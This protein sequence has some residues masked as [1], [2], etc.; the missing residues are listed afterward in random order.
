M[1]KHPVT[2]PPDVIPVQGISDG[3]LE[4]LCQLL[5]DETLTLL[6]RYGNTPHAQHREALKIV[7]ESAI[8]CLY[9]PS[10]IRRAFPLE[11]GMGKTTIVKALCQLIV[12]QNLDR[13]ILVTCY[14]IEDLGELRKEM[15]ESGVP[16]KEVAIVHSSADYAK[17]YPSV[18]KDR[19]PYHRILLASHERIKT[20]RKSYAGPDEFM[21]FFGRDHKLRKRDLVLWDEGLIDAESYHVSKSDLLDSIALWLDRYERM[22]AEWRLPTDEWRTKYCEFKEYL[23]D[24]QKKLWGATDDL[25]SLPHLNSQ[26]RD[27]KYMTSNLLCRRK[28]DNAGHAKN[29]GRLAE[30]AERGQVRVVPL[31]GDAGLVQYE[32]TI[33]ECFNKILILDASCPIRE[34][35]KYDGKLTIHRLP[36]T[37]NYAKVCLRWVDAKGSKSSFENDEDGKHF[38]SYADYFLWLVE[39]MYGKLDE[40]IVFCHLDRE[41]RVRE[42]INKAQE[43][44]GP[45]AGSIHLLHWGM[46][47]ASNKYRNARW[48]FFWGIQYLPVQAIA[49]LIIGQIGRLDYSFLDR[50]IDEVQGSEIAEGVYQAASRGHSRTT[51]EGMA[52]EQLID[53]IIPQDAARRV[54]PLLEEVMPGIQIEQVDTGHFPKPV[55][56]NAKD[57][58]ELGETIRAHVAN[59]SSSEVKVSTKALIKALELPIKSGS[60]L[61]KNAMS[62]AA[63]RLQGWYRT[64]KGFARKD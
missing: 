42:V 24:A 33:D 57:Y 28:G 35:A 58:I 49:A 3:E 13:G 21:Q 7:C 41:T 6:G 45:G 40:G 25:I 12:K 56:K 59:Q 29:L 39:H 55:R 63:D 23:E 4:R 38:K 15:I 52:G 47:R 34:L 11:T 5:L 19:I 14:R 2:I 62:Y 60:S 1:R 54:L 26:W 27:I 43:L 64:G 36:I 8:R 31:R 22:L 51:N 9:S 50:E 32:Q 16:E 17:Q 46:H 53:L 20:E 61:W 37:K 44:R 18:E 30:F 10:D 48:V